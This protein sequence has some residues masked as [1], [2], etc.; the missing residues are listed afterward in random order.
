M[1]VL[2]T[3]P[4][5]IVI[6]KQYICSVT[7]NVFK[8][9]IPNTQDFYIYLLEIKVISKEDYATLQI[10]QEKL[11]KDKPSNP[12]YLDSSRTQ[13]KLQSVNRPKA[14]LEESDASIIFDILIKLNWND[15]KRCMQISRYQDNIDQIMNFLCVL[16]IQRSLDKGYH[17]TCYSI[18]SV[19]RITVGSSAETPHHSMDLVPMSKMICNEFCSPSSKICKTL[20]QDYFME[21]VQAYFHENFIMFAF[22]T[23][24]KSILQRLK[25]DIES[26]TKKLIRQYSESITKDTFDL[27]LEGCLDNLNSSISPL[28]EYDG[29]STAHGSQ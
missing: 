26:T 6:L 17:F 1:S 9:L 18:V 16:E 21:F 19:M 4:H 11:A 27:V 23:L 14:D 3:T 22:Q 8:E 2:L 25:D 5:N 10:I 24:Q 12:R 7:V 28:T 13:E 29:A 15:L 20:K